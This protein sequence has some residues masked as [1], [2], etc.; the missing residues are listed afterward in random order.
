MRDSI[1]FQDDGFF[2][3]AFDDRSVEVVYNHD[4]GVEKKKSFHVPLENLN[5]SFKKKLKVIYADSPY[6][7]LNKIALD[8]VE[9]EHKDSSHENSGMSDFSSQ[10]YLT[11]EYDKELYDVVYTCNY[12]L[13]TVLSFHSMEINES[14]FNSLK[15]FDD[16]LSLVEESFARICEVKSWSDEIENV[17]DGYSNIHNREIADLIQKY[18]EIIDEIIPDIVNEIF[19]NYYNYSD[20]LVKDLSVIEGVKVFQWSGMDSYWTPAVCSEIRPKIVSVCLEKFA[21]NDKFSHVNV[22]DVYYS[23]TKIRLSEFEK[24]LQN[25]INK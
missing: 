13:N 10:K 6:H 5:D 24:N 16:H 11:I 21:K 12:N 20:S 23:A 22:E 17:S 25:I 7:S 9:S 8:L 2:A 1:G 18:W 4:S 3:G 19:L 14:F 15:K